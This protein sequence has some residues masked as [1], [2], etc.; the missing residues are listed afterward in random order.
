MPIY[1]EWHEM[2]GTIEIA[3]YNTI[4][5]N[6]N[7]FKPAKQFMYVSKV[8]YNLFTFCKSK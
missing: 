7:L 2:V 3:T 4:T 6:V 1:I 8:T 5:L